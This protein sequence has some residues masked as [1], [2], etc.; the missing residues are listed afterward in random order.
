MLRS[1]P[2]NKAA[3]YV[4][5]HNKKRQRCMERFLLACPL[6]IAHYC[7]CVILIQ[8]EIKDSLF[9]GPHSHSYLTLCALVFGG[10]SSSEN[11]DR[12]VYLDERWSTCGGAEAQIKSPLSFLAVCCRR[13]T[14]SR[15]PLSVVPCQ[16]LTFSTA[17]PNQTCQEVPTAWISLAPTGAGFTWYSKCIKSVL[18]VGESKLELQQV[19]D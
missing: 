6:H 19:I 3:R 18:R 5:Q 11:T 13:G 15:R 14:R 17:S 16:T 2:P 4:K 7:L 10:W 8:V 1:A 9:F 12:R